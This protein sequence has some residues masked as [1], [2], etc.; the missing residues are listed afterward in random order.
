[1]YPIVE[2]D[3]GHGGQ[4]HKYRCDQ[5]HVRQEN[6]VAIE[7]LNGVAKAT[8]IIDRKPP[9]FKKNDPL[10]SNLDTIIPYYSHS[11]RRL[12]G[13]LGGCIEDRAKTT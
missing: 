11:D 3:P 2:D 6:L 8:P 4:N 1:M 10:E 5:A 12:L 7:L 13:Q 9:T